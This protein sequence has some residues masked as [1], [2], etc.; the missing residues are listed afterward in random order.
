VPTPDNNAAVAFLRQWSVHGPWILTAI[1]T[2]KKG[3][4]TAT[5]DSDNEDE[6]LAWLEEYNNV[7]NIYFHVNPATRALKKKANR[8]DVKELSWLHVDIDPRAGEDLEE[9]QQRALAQLQ[10]PPEGVPKPTC[11]I[12][13]GGGYQGFWKIRDPFQI[14]GDIERAEEAKRWNMQLEV[15]FGADHCHNIDRIMRLPGTVN[16]P[17]AKKKRKGRKPAL[18]TVVEF[19]AARAYDLSSFTPAPLVQDAKSAGF[20]QQVNLKTGN[21]DRLGSIDELDNHA[22]TEVPDWCK[23]RIVQGEDPDAQQESRSENLWSVVCELVRCGV[24]DEWVYSVIT[25]PEF[26]ISDSVLDKGRGAERYALRQISQAHE[27]AIHP[28]LR[29]MNEKHAVI[30]NLGGKCVVVQELHDYALDRPQITVQSFQAIRNRYGHKKIRVGE[31]P[32][33]GEPKYKPL[34]HW[35]LDHEKRRQYETVVFVPGREVHGSYNLWKGFAHEAVPGD[36]SLF[37][38]HIHDNIC[39]GNEEHYKYV[40][41]W[42]ARAVQNPDE[43][44]SSAIVLRGRQGTG[45]S[46]FAKTFGRI[47]GRHFLQV[48]NPKH[49]MGNFNAH[50]QDCVVLFGDEAFAAGRKD[51]ENTLKALITEET[52]QI[53][54]KGVDTI[55]AP[56]YTHIILASNSEWVVP[57][58]VDDRRFF[59]LDVSSSKKQNTKYFGAIHD[60]MESGGYEALL[61]FLLHHDLKEFKPY[62]IPQTRALQEQK[63]LSFKSEEE[64]W[65]DKLNHGQLVDGNSDWG[66]EIRKR[67]MLEE[68]LRYTQQLGVNQRSSSTTL[69]KFLKRACPPGWPRIRRR[70]VHDTDE[71]G[72]PTMERHY[73]WQFPSL[74]E[75]RDHWDKHFGGPYDWE[76]VTVEDDDET[77]F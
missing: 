57:A 60:Q 53:E 10:S 58:D 30:G 70:R 21:V 1:D 61:H 34:G 48:S 77:P 19:S 8:E 68:Y 44:G 38:Q 14:D 29:K 32:K 16:L 56:N 45:K 27:H 62:T 75:C 41:G 43:P 5:F 65:F 22:A 9:E 71:R 26:R 63:I 28:K 6:L 50:L 15:L 66:K 24:S 46:F 35:W 42:M 55:V 40:V 33:T 23:V 12:F 54:K 11:I 72:E 25:D 52:L 49:L 31:N 64:W 36:C 39:Q 20:A 67:R 76:D 74:Q 69:G 18:A 73:F 37:M 7:R 13:S 2:D 3:I 4:T 59:V 47:W 51:H 17:D